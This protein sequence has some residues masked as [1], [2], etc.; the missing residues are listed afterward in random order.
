MKLLGKNYVC[1][2]TSRKNYSRNIDQSSFRHRF[3]TYDN[4]TLHFLA[5]L[6]DNFAH[7]QAKLLDKHTIQVCLDCEFGLFNQHICIKSI[8]RN[9]RSIFRL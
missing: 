8:L 9:F 1:R 2:A 6:F 4:I 5:R 3:V 7:E